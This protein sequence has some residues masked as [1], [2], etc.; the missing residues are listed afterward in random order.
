MTF[1]SLTSTLFLS[2]SSL[3]LL[4]RY[5]YHL[6]TTRCAVASSSLVYKTGKKFDL[7]DVKIKCK[8]LTIVNRKY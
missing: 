6:L 8:R 5:V 1:A 7:M 4:Y 3:I 2:I